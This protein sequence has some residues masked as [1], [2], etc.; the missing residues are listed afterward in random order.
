[1]NTRF[2]DVCYP[3]QQLVVD[4]S[5]M[6]FRRRLE[7]RQYLLSKPI[8][9][10]MKLYLCSESTSGY[11]LHLNFYM[12]ANTMGPERRHGEQVVRDLAEAYQGVKHTIYMDSFFSTPGL[13]RDLLQ[14]RTLACG[15][16]ER[17]AKGHMCQNEK[18]EKG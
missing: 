16:K 11:V 9:Y 14:N 18:T 17:L 8:K 6:P 7:F 3:E 10:W 2:P 15:T 5:M 4:K 13:L 12:G 1:M